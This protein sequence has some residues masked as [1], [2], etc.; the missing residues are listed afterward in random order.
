V[1]KLGFNVHFDEPPRAP[2]PSS[3]PVKAPLSR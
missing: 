3:M 2:A 1:V